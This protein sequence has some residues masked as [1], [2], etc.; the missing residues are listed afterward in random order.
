LLGG[1]AETKFSSFELFAARIV[2]G[3]LG[4]MAMIQ[5]RPPICHDLLTSTPQPELPHVPSPFLP[6]AQVH[7]LWIITFGTLNPICRVFRYFKPPTVFF[8]G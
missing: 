4:G 2:S 7:N 6:L 5:V 1:S 8:F 3:A